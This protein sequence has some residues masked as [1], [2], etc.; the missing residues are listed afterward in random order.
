M[1]KRLLISIV[2]LIVGIIIYLVFD[3]NMMGKSNFV[4]TIIRN[5]LPD[6]CWTFSLYFLGIIFMAN[7]SKKPLFMNA[8][9]VLT[10]A[11]LFEF[12]QYYHIV[13]GTFD[14]VDVLIYIIS[15]FISCLVEKNIRRKENEEV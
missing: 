11:L 8:I 13:K 5:Y 10:V 2:L 1:K 3:I 12:S 7:I 9:Y 15:T 6:I 14:I 4:F